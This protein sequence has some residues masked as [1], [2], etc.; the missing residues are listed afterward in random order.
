MMK[1]IVLLLV[2]I[3]IIGV[4]LWFSKD[5]F[6]NTVKPQSI[7]Q[8]GFKAQFYNKGEGQ[9]KTAIIILGGGPYGDF[10]GSEFAEA[11]HTGL[12]LPYHRQ[13]GLPPLIEEIPLEYFEKAMNWLIGQPGVNPD[14]ILVMGASTNAELALLLAA[15]FPDKIKGVI[16][17]C[18]SA[19]TWSNTVFPWSSEELKTKWTYHGEPIPFLAM[20][21][22]KGNET[23]TIETLGYWNSGLDDTLQV[24]QAAIKVEKINGPILLITPLDDKVWPSFRMSEMI[25]SRLEESQ[26]EFSCQNVTYENA[27]HTIMAQYHKAITETKGQMKIGDKMYEFDYGG[28]AAG[29]LAA[30]VDSRKRVKEFVDKQ[31]GE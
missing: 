19:V 1:K 24:D 30:Q 13:E 11:G 18:P 6:S 12:S 7:S 26:F 15:T 28:T 2:G 3:V 9:N 10:W 5:Y 22:I 27:G 17:I 21:K 8:N 25:T 31:A 23:N 16:A 29:N 14:K 20:E 4:F